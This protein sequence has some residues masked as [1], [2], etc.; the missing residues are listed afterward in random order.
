V[1]KDQLNSS[2]DSHREVSSRKYQQDKQRKFNDWLRKND[3]NLSTSDASLLSEGSKKS[4]KAL[5]IRERQK[6]FKD[7]LLKL[8]TRNASI[9]Q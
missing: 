6:K 1:L 8:K 7:H 9:Q 2:K 3:I 5:T 4:S